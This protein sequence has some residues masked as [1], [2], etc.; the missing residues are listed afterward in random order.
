MKSLVT[1]IGAL[2]FATTL[3]IA[4]DQPAGPPPEGTPPKEHKRP[5]PE[6][7]FKG[8]DKDGNGTVNLGEFKGG[9]MG[10]RD[11]AKAEEIFK[12]MDKDANGELTFDE[13][14]AG[15]PQRP[16]GERG[17]GGHGPGKGGEG[18]DNPP[19]PPAGQ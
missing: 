2:A 18:G 17:K 10:Q 19:P 3:S 5:S 14:K 16:P 11:P 12:K 15:R 8:L 4:Q 7:I 9:R 1:T 6:E 13:F